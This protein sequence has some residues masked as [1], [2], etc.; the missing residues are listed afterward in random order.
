MTNRRNKIYLGHRNNKCFNTVIERLTIIFFLSSPDNGNLDSSMTTSSELVIPSPTKFRMKKSRHRRSNS[1][2]S[3]SSIL[4]SPSKTQTK[5]AVHDELESTQQNLRHC[6]DSEITPRVFRY[7]G[8]GTAIRE[9][10]SN[11]GYHEGCYQEMGECSTREGRD[12]RSLNDVCFGCD[13]ECSDHMCG[14][15]HSSQASADVESNLGD[16]PCSPCTPS[17]NL[18]DIVENKNL[19][20]KSKSSSTENSGTS[21]STQDKD[22]NENLNCP[23]ESDLINTSGE[24]MYIH[25]LAKEDNS[26][27]NYCVKRTSSD[28][29]IVVTPQRI[30]NQH[31]L[32]SIES[33]ESVPVRHR[34]RVVRPRK[35]CV[36]GFQVPE[37]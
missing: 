33:V 32:S 29:D 1:K 27:M 3:L 12:D 30:H 6:E 23:L 18:D 7:L 28:S 37:I 25:D 2:G 15:K 26:V 4:G 36:T 16:S 11:D 31:R 5:E 17:E 9:Y 10:K 35:V 22:S 34:E 24:C 21:N 14:S 19:E 20:N 8:P 13:G